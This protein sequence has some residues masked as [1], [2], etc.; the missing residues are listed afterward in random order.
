MSEA[1]VGHAQG[2]EVSSGQVLRDGTSGGVSVL[3]RG[4]LGSNLE[5][6]GQ[7]MSKL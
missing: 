6:T 7:N 4:F 1:F 3:G 5:V 2:H